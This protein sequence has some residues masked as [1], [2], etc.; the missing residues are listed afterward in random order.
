MGYLH[1]PG[2]IIF[3]YKFSNRKMLEG[4][5]RLINENLCFWSHD[6]MVH[7]FFHSIFLIAISFWF[8]WGYECIGKLIF[9][10]LQKF[11]PIWLCS[12]RD[13]VTGCTSHFFI[14]H[15]RAHCEKYL[16]HDHSSHSNIREHLNSVSRSQGK[17]QLSI[18]SREFIQKWTNQRLCTVRVLDCDPVELFTLQVS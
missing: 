3:Q 7:L 12:I 10:L 14:A 2:F 6:V 16:E 8:R 18:F 4:A 1:L 17:N 13:Q 15:P 5:C 9:L 11:G